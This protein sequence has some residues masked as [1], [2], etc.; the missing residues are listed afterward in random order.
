MLDKQQT[1]SSGFP[2]TMVEPFIPR[3]MAARG[4]SSKHK[5]LIRENRRDIL[6]G[7]L[8]DHEAGDKNG[9]EQ[10]R[11][12]KIGATRR[13]EGSSRESQ[14]DY[15]HFLY[16]ARGS[17][18]ETQY[19]IHLS[20]RLGYL[21]GADAEQMIGQTKQTFACLHGLI[22][23]VEKESG[24]FAKTVA[25]LTSLLVIGLARWSSIP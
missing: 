2:C 3:K 13:R 20:R 14:K 7:A 15:L 6:N 11:Q 24:K 19:F 4:C 25:V 22:K 10:N 23:A 8:N 16:I 12:M 9:W 21:P 18:S 1:S 5:N 17:L